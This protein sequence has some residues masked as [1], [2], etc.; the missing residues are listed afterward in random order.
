[1]SISQL[2]YYI[3]ELGARLVL[4]LNG[5]LI[6]SSSLDFIRQGSNLILISFLHGIK[7]AHLKSNS[8]MHYNLTLVVLLIAGLCLSS[9]AL[10]GMFNALFPNK[11]R[12]KLIFLLGLLAFFLSLLLVA[13]IEL[14]ARQFG[15]EASSELEASQALYD[16]FQDPDSPESQATEQREVTAI[17]DMFQKNWECC[18]P[19]GAKDWDKYR[20]NPLKELAVYPVSCCKN[21][22]KVKKVDARFCLPNLSMWTEGCSTKMHQILSGVLLIIRETTHYVLLFTIFAAILWMSL[23]LKLDTDQPSDQNNF[24]DNFYPPPN[25]YSSLDQNVYKK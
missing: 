17:W 24:N 11:K 21:T 20:P 13:N 15:P 6:L 8:I 16:W 23:E 18:G 7:S 2:I 3:L 10:Y 4:L 9:L 19:N 1:M 5:V 12:A 25:Y 22:I 14:R